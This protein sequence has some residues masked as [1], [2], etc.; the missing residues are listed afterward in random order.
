MDPRL[1]RAEQLGG[2]TAVQYEDGSARGMRGLLVRTPSGFEFE[3]LP[4]R[5]LDVPRAYFKG[6]SLAWQAPAGV[7]REAVYAPDGDAFERSFFGGLVTTCGLMAFGPPGRDRFG[8][9]GQHGRINHLAA[10]SVAHRVVCEGAQRWV[11]ITGVVREASLFGHCLRLERTWRIAFD[12]P[13]LH[14]H[15]RVTNEG[16]T[17]A[18]HMLLYHCNAGYP[19]LDENMRLDVSQ[20]AMHPRDAAAA[21]GLAQWDRGGPPDAQFKEQVFVHQPVA[22]QDGC[23]VA[24]MSNRK[25]ANGRGLALVVRFDP[26][27]L[28]A[29]FTWRMLGVRDYVMAVEPANC[30][31]IEGRVAAGERGTLP[32]LEPGETRNYDLRFEVLEGDAIDTLARAIRPS[33]GSG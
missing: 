30:P 14:L 8:S 26:V 5:A 32:F 24:M 12:S 28:P 20:H 33:T 23:A 17:A 15:D 21:A 4:D 2:V 31:T 29:L 7:V 6:T 11:E 16:G 1:G 22:L 19:L 13:V 25:L 27:Q 9:W 3:C 18:P 10:E